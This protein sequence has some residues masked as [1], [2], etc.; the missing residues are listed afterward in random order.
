MSKVILLLVKCYHFKPLLFRV[1]S[2]FGIF[3]MLAYLLA[4][5]MLQATKKKVK[6]GS[7]IQ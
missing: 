3:V 5:K 6:V 2:H 4:V 1:L 7:Y